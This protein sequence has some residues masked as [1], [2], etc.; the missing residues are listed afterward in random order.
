MITKKHFDFTVSKSKEPPPKKKKKKVKTPPPVIPDPA[1]ILAAPLP[2]Y[3]SYVFSTALANRGAYE[4]IIKGKY[5]TIIAYHQA[6][7][8]PKPYL[9]PIHCE[10][11]VPEELKNEPALY[12]SD[13]GPIHSFSEDESKKPTKKQPLKKPR[14]KPQKKLQRKISDASFSASTPSPVSVEHRLDREAYS[15]GRESVPSEHDSSSSDRDQEN[16]DNEFYQPKHN[17]PN[18]DIFDDDEDF[19]IK[20]EQSM[21]DWNKMSRLKTNSKL[22]DD[23]DRFFHNNN[24]KSAKQNSQRLSSAKKSNYPSQK[25][26]LQNSK[27]PTKGQKKQNFSNP[28]PSPLNQPTSLSKSQHIPDQLSEEDD[29]DD[30]NSGSSENEEMGGEGDR[31]DQSVPIIPVEPEVEDAKSPTEQLM[32]RHIHP[33]INRANNE[34]EPADQKKDEES[35][36]DQQIDSSYNISGQDRGT[37]HGSTV[38]SSIKGAPIKLSGSSDVLSGSPRHSPQLSPFASYRGRP[39]T[40]PA[41]IVN[42]KQALVSS[43]RRSGDMDRHLEA[44]SIKGHDSDI[45]SPGSV[46]EITQNEGSNMGMSRPTTLHIGNKASP[47]QQSHPSL[48]SVDPKRPKPMH[49]PHMSPHQMEVSSV[50]QRPNPSPSSS[51]DNLCSP[52]IPMHQMQSPSIPV[53]PPSSSPI[54]IHDT[55]NGSNRSASP[56]SP[57]IVNKSGGQYPPGVHSIISPVITNHKSPPISRSSPSLQAISSAGF[58]CAVQ[59]S[60]SPAQINNSIQRMHATQQDHALQ[61]V[62]Y[63]RHR[64]PQLS[65]SLKTGVRG[66]PSALDE[67]KRIP[68][69]LYNQQARAYPALQHGI[70]KELNH[71]ARGFAQVGQDSSHNFHGIPGHG[72]QETPRTVHTPAHVVP[73]ALKSH[74]AMQRNSLGDSSRVLHSIGHENEEQARY[75]SM[76]HGGPDSNRSHHGLPRVAQSSPRSHIGLPSHSQDASRTILGLTQSAQEVARNVLGSQESSSRGHHSAPPSASESTRSHHGLSINAQELSRPHHAFAHQMHEQSRYPP[77]MAHPFHLN[78][79]LHESAHGRSLHDVAHSVRPGVHGHSFQQ[80]FRSLTESPVGKSPPTQSLF[81]HAHGRE[82]PSPS[83][84]TKAYPSPLMERAMIE[85]SM[86]EHQQ[87]AR[88]M[89]QQ[90]SKKSFSV[91]SLTSSSDASERSKG[92]CLNGQPNSVSALSRAGYTAQQRSHMFGPLPG[93]TRGPSPEFLKLPPHVQQMYS[94]RGLSPYMNFPHFKG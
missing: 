2:P 4:V 9:Q 52:A 45:R 6:Q 57:A 21:K 5:N 89:E 10:P 59:R 8:W 28:R 93:Y 66:T 39:A 63:Q 46:T 1:P 65:A 3:K 40:Y 88:L 62:L 92:Q 64:I 82:F 48:S 61:S 90:Q 44:E 35:K 14:K 34:P 16:S 69:M 91:E 47:P 27:V 42:P 49:I 33:T 38:I 22:Y 54:I 19:L 85:K 83:T 17:K 87:Q 84:G 94:A 60:I 41:E 7:K 72:G 29:D 30:D 58:N 78:R 76:G 20:R 56:T 32:E 73:E 53:K 51:V 75:L 37:E 71:L 36:L 25:K 86:L 74:L 70:Q 18:M 55:V 67:D 24:R 13:N 26:H 15:S 23:Y 81:Q 31:C 80:G 68:G 43:P 11:F 12:S 77:G 79:T 50:I